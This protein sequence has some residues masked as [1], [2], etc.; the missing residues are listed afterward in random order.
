MQVN[1]LSFAL[2]VTLSGSAC[3]SPG[4]VLGFL[5]YSQFPLSSRTLSGTRVS[6]L[7]RESP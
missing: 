5:P 1:G 6:V 3:E 4:S 2:H 7:N